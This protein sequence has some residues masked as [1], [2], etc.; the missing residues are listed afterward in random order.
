[1]S[2]NKHRHGEYTSKSKHHFQNSISKIGGS[3]A[4]DAYFA[5]KH[6][7]KSPEFGGSAAGAYFGYSEQETESEIDDFR[8]V[9]CHE[10]NYDKELYNSRSKHDYHH[11]KEYSPE[12]SSRV[13]QHPRKGSCEEYH[14]SQ[15]TLHTSQKSYTSKRSSNYRC[16]P[17]SRDHYGSRD[18]FSENEDYYNRTSSRTTDRIETRRRNDAPCYRSSN[19][20]DFEHH[21]SS[22][23]SP[24]QCLPR[25][26]HLRHDYR[27]R[28]KR[29]PSE[30]PTRESRHSRR[31]TKYHSSSHHSRTD[32][33]HQES[34]QF[35]SRHGDHVF[36]STYR[37]R[38]HY[39]PTSSSCSSSS[40][41][42]SS[43]SYH[44]GHNESCHSRSRTD[45]RSSVRH[46]SRRRSQRQRT[47]TSSRNQ[48]A[49]S[50]GCCSSSDT[51]SSASSSEYSSDDKYSLS[52]SCYD[53]RVCSS[54]ISSSPDRRYYNQY[55]KRHHQHEKHLSPE[56]SYHHQD[57]QI[58]QIKSLSMAETN[59][60]KRDNLAE[61]S[62]PMHA[63]EDQNENRVRS[64]RKLKVD[65][66]QQ[67]F[68]QKF[69]R[70][71]CMARLILSRTWTPPRI[72]FHSQPLN[73]R[74]LF[75]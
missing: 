71:E 43:S 32:E 15:R 46:K 37:R 60:C 26:S 65:A 2:F 3:A 34:K 33:R 56:R 73:W 64:T 41:N 12:R 75:L 21:R 4:R 40:D 39:K 16:H 9:R 69:D 48:S 61:D 13:Y 53:D 25:K 31:H 28:T 51:E 11:Y 49:P 74:G 57:R 45:K 8:S 22:H 68:R 55:D 10:R 52:H 72:G 47:K 1:M 70:I 59:S 30:S 5:P 63:S 66:F 14:S 42:E 27:W 24:S 36:Y 6:R 7:Q 67:E 62:L 58:Y 18:S 19:Y 44:S 17:H 35:H 38:E 29:T 50:S 54:V 20:K 23:R